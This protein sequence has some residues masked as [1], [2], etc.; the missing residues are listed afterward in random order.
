MQEL[1]LLPERVAGLAKAGRCSWQRARDGKGSASEAKAL[2]QKRLGFILGYWGCL[3]CL[4]IFSVPAALAAAPVDPAASPTVEATAEPQAPTVEASAAPLDERGWF[5]EQLQR[6][7]DR[8]ALFYRYGL[9]EQAQGNTEQAISAFAQAWTLD[10]NLYAAAAELAQIYLEHQQPQQAVDVLTQLHQRWRVEADTYVLLGRSQLALGNR[11]EAIKA[12][13]TALLL[14]PDH[15]IQAE[16]DALGQDV[17][18]PPRPLAEPLLA[19]AEELL[20]KNS[21]VSAQATLRMLLDTHPEFQPAYDR[22]ATQLEAAGQFKAA[23]GWREQL[24]ELNP[25]YQNNSALLGRWQL[26]SGYLD[27]A[28][29]LLQNQ[30]ECRPS[31]EAAR[32]MG[33]LYRQRN[34]WELAQAHYQAFL[35]RWPTDGDLLAGLAQSSLERGQLSTARQALAAIKTPGPD[36]L[37]VRARLHQLSGEAAEGLADLKRLVSLRNRPEYRKALGLAYAEAGMGPEARRELQAYL[38]QRPAEAADLAPLLA[39]LERLPHRARFEN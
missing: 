4:G 27:R 30:L 12:Y 13:E 9:F 22:L 31:V 26:W 16:R 2:D 11:A 19:R 3:G 15:A 39:S 21:P 17:S 29:E 7:P 5:T 10:A 25:C 20:R 38:K 32:W 23:A 6:Y 14:R 28:A 35:K 37:Y 34:Q 1:G 8:A 24:Q 33:Q 18:L 36:A